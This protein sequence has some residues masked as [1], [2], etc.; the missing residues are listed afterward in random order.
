MLSGVSRSCPRSPLSASNLLQQ[1]LQSGFRQ[2]PEPSKHAGGEGGVGKPALGI[3]P[4]SSVVHSDR[5][6]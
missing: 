4:T 5:Y 1:D 2:L 6:G 3:F